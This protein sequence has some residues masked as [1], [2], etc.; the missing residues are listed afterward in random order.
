MHMRPEEWVQDNLFELLL[1]DAERP[2]PVVSA[3]FLSYIAPYWFCGDSDHA[4]RS[5]SA[6]LQTLSKLTERLEA[7]KELIPAT[8]ADCLLY[9]GAMVD[10]PL[11][12]ED[13]IRVDK[14]CVRFIVC[15]Q[16]D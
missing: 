1:H 15:Q 13:L 4:V 16:W 8:I 14:R 10:F 11:H 3:R 7:A 12:P 6:C 2:E 5:W 9:A